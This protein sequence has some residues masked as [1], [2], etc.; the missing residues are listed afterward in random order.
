MG[1]M[2]AGMADKKSLLTAGAG[3]SFSSFICACLGFVFYT[4]VYIGEDSVTTIGWGPGAH[5]S[6][7]RLLPARSLTRLTEGAWLS[8]MRSRRSCCSGDRGLPVRRPQAAT[9]APSSASSSPPSLARP[10]RPGPVARA[11]AQARRRLRQ[12]RPRARLTRTTWRDH[13]RGGEGHGQR[14]S[15]SDGDGVTRHPNKAG[16]DVG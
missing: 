2:A 13:E 12:A 9:S 6:P 1:A 5:R 3:L 11:R 14:P 15:E 8:W 10:Q 4:N 16:L 7:R